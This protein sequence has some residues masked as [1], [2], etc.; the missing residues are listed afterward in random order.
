MLAE[1]TFNETL[2][3]G[4][5]GS[6]CALRD[7]APLRNNRRIMQRVGSGMSATGPAGPLAIVTSVTKRCYLTADLGV[8]TNVGVNLWSDQSGNG[9]HFTQGVSSGFEPTYTQ[10]DST[11]NNKG[12]VT[13]DGS[14]DFMVNTSLTYAANY[15]TLMVFKAIT[16]T[17]TDSLMGS[18]NTTADRMVLR[19]RTATPQIGMVGNGGGGNNVAATLET[20][21]RLECHFTGTADYLHIGATTA[22]GVTNVG[23]TPGV[24]RTLFAGQTNAQ[25]SNIALAV[26]FVCDNRP[27]PSELTAIDQWIAGYYG[28][29]VSI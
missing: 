10:T 12:S 13:S 6:Q 3:Y 22:N 27:T 5:H 29:A 25:F 26:Y 24:G 23:T 20:W 18:G 16:W 19:Q 28:G 14:D 21:F 17:S 4:A 15:W 9:F 11:L 8:T 7:R 1:P 2:R